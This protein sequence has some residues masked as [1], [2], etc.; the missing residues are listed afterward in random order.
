MSCACSRDM[1][2][3]SYYI[4]QVCVIVDSSLC[5]SPEPA[6]KPLPLNT[7]S[8]VHPWARFSKFSRPLSSAGDSVRPSELHRPREAQSH[9][10]LPRASLKQKLLFRV[11]TAFRCQCEARSLRKNHVRHSTRPARLDITDGRALMNTAEPI[12]A[13]CCSQLVDGEQH[14]SCAHL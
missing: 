7:S 1:L 8:L 2:R 4:C 11:T 6:D 5:I 14:E 12:P 10:R 9:V 13:F 3:K